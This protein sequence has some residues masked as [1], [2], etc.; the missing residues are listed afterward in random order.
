MHFHMNTIE[1]LKSIILV[2]YL[3]FYLLFLIKNQENY[4]DSLLTIFNI[5]AKRNK[6]KK[7][8]ADKDKRVARLI[9]SI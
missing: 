9:F 8:G 6:K 2:I 5:H 4:S 7:M 1:I 3:H